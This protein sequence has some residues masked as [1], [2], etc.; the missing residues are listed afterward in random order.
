VM[1]L[2]PMNDFGHLVRLTRPGRMVLAVS[3]ILFAYI[4]VRRINGFS[5]VL[6]LAQL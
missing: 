1:T 2:I 5:A 6:E 4:S 3:E